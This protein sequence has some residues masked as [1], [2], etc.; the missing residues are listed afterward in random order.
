[1]PRLYDFQGRNPVYFKN[2]SGQTI[3]P[4]DI[5][6]ILRKYP[7]IQF[8]FRQYHELNCSLKIRAGAGAVNIFQNDVCQKLKMLFGDI[9]DILIEEDPS[10]GS[11][12]KIISFIS[13]F[14]I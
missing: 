6:K 4:V 11:D 13:E 10:L 2:R 5:S 8:Q 14:S 7:I 12:G 1:M 9:S 3:N